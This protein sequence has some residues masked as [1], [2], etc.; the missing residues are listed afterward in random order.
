MDTDDAIVA[1]FTDH[2][3]AE[4]AVKELSAAGFEMKNLHV[5]VRAAP[6]ADR[7]AAAAD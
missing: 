7:M 3:S 2:Q 1:V 5:G 4:T 6:L